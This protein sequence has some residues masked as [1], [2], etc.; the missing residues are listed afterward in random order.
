[1]EYSGRED[2]TFIN[3]NSG[4]EIARQMSQEPLLHQAMGGL[5][6]EKTDLSDVH[7]VLDVY[8]GPGSWAL[9]MAFHYPNIEIIA[10][11]ANQHLIEYARAQARV[12]GLNNVHFICTDPVWEL[13]FPDDTFDMINARFISTFLRTRDWPSTIQ[14]FVRVSKAGAIIRLIE[15]DEPFISNSRACERLKQLSSQALAQNGQSFHPLSGTVNSCMTP[16]LRTFLRQVGCQDIQERA[17]VISYSSG[18]PYSTLKHDNLKVLYKLGQPFLCAMGVAT[19]SELDE[20]YEEML[21]D[22]LANCFQALWYFLSCWGYV[23]KP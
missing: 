23:T 18:T 19:Q 20:L 22:M 12:Q 14:E 15:S 5:F 1:M 7:Y 9:E 10:I 13:D 2:I 11:D 16:H 3:P 6:A 21:T 8:C 17:H 4:A